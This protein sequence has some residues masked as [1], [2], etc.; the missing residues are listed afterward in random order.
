GRPAFWDDNTAGVLERVC[1]V[2]PTP[3]RDINPAIP[4]WLADAIAKLQAKE[5]ARRFA[6][7]HEV[8]ELFSTRLAQ[9]AITPVATSSPKK[10]ANQAEKPSPFRRKGLVAAGVLLL[11][12]AIWEL[13]ALVKIWTEHGPA[14]SPSS[15]K[16]V[17]GKVLGVTPQELDLRRDAVASNL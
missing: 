1:T 8:A 3:I 15:F 13:G 11:L 5:L 14:E 16:D 17:A 6:T 12:L 7:A 10:E 4:E 2:S 9:V